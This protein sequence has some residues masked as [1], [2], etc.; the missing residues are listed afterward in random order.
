MPAKQRRVDVTKEDCVI[1]PK[2]DGRV[3]PQLTVVVSVTATGLLLMCGGTYPLWLPGL[4][5]AENMDGYPLFPRIPVFWI[6]PEFSL[7]FQWVLFVSGAMLLLLVSLGCFLPLKNGWQK[8]AGGGFILICTLLI[9]EDQH[10]FV[11]W[12]Y[13]S[14]LFLAGWVFFRPE[15]ALKFARV[16]IVGV[17]FFSAI[18]KLDYQF[19][20]TTG[21]QML[22]ISMSLIGLD[23]ATW[24][25]LLVSAFVLLLPIL[26]IG[27]ALGLMFPMTRWVS[28]GLGTLMHAGLVVV[29]GPWGMGNEAS[30]LIWNGFIAVELCILFGWRSRSGEEASNK[31]LFWPATTG[32][33]CLFGLVV[34]MPLLDSI[35]LIDHWPAWALYAPKTSRCRLW[36]H[37]W[38]VRLLAPEKQRWIQEGSDDSRR[39]AQQFGWREVDLAKWSLQSLKTPLYPQ[40]RFQLGVCRDLVQQWQLDRAFFVEVQSSSNVWTGQR[41]SKK[42]SSRLELERASNRFWGNS[43]SRGYYRH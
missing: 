16:S 19:V 7:L 40:D 37:D 18:S 27:V 23:T 32:L 38:Q 36:I 2:Q 3:F 26:E 6:F 25:P 11:P 1:G 13:Q 34:C 35:R 4:P 29:L 21:R 17:Y 20:M 31:S 41:K 9:L 15:N 10:R 42:I 30:V 22:E 5:S 33:R 43:Q 28:L 8:T 24:P 39:S 14:L 12:V